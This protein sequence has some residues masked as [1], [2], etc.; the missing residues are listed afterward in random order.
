[1]ASGDVFSNMA[2]TVTSPA[3]ITIQPAATVSVMINYISTDSVNTEL[4]GNHAGL[5]SYAMFQND[6]TGTGTKVVQNWQNNTNMRLFLTNG[7]FMLVV[8]TAGAV[9]FSYSGIEV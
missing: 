9:K 5:L 3:T 7:D 6:G 1:M 2:Q 4:W 8:S